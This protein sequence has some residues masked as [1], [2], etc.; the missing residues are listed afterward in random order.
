M[1][2]RTHTCGEITLN[3]LNLTASLNGWISKIRDLGSLIFVD[4]RD[5]YGTTQVVFNEKT[6]KKIFKRVKKLGLE[7]VIGVEGLV[8]KRPKE[9]INES[10]VT[11][12]IDIDRITTG[13]T[14]TTR[15]KMSTIRQIIESLESQFG[16]SVPRNE[17]VTEAE[18]QG[19][20]KDK[21][22]EIIQN[23]LK[24]GDLFEPRS[25]FIQRS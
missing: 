13:I 22:D 7:D 9:A 20:E 5:R 11:G 3:D 23:L 10:M 18:V 14:A 15:N 21:S 12:K 17:I 16:K 6:N 24:S 25:G 8:I 4:L 19:I 1:I 2:K